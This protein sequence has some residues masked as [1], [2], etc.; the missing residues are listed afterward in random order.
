MAAFVL[1]VSEQSN[2]GDCGETAGRIIME[3]G[4]AVRW[5]EITLDSVI[6]FTVARQAA[7]DAVRAYAGARLFTATGDVFRPESVRAVY[8]P[9]WRFRT[10]AMCEY[11]GAWDEEQD[12]E[13][14]DGN[15]Q[16][17]TDRHYIS[18]TVHYDLDDD[19]LICGAEEYTDS[20]AGRFPYDL[21]QTEDDVPNNAERIDIVPCTVTAQDAWDEAQEGIRDFLAQRIEDDLCGE[22][23]TQ[24][25]EVHELNI[26]YGDIVPECILLPLWEISF[27]HDGTTYNVCVNGQT[28]SVC[29]D[30]PLAP[31]RTGCLAAAAAILS[32]LP[33]LWQ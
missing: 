9:F 13:D 15:W 23:Q 14:C 12:Y 8:V 6:P 7:L 29:G 5:A 21:A 31:R 33:V 28:G 3:T 27:I 18:G 24:S 22:Y 11:R 4:N 26:S 32:I 2:N 25:A 1:A 20:F 19:I 10:T 16:T 30:L 17:D